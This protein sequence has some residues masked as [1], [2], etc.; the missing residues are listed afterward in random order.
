MAKKQIVWSELASLQLE[1]VLDYF[2]NRNGN[3][4]YSLKL[5]DDVDKLVNSIA[6]NEQLGRL[7]SNNFTRVVPK[8]QYLIFYEISDRQIE[9]ISFWDNRQNPDRKKVK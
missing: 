3:A 5:L 8:K 7:T 6:E 9:I 2:T 1:S 4:N